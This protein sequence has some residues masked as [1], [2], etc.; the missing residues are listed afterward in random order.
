M[1]GVQGIEQRARLDSTY[2]A[3]NDP[4]GSPTE[5][6]LQQVIERDVRLERI[7]LAFDSEDVRLLDMQLG[8]I[9]DH[10]DSLFDRNR[11]RKDAEQGRFPCTRSATNEERLPGRNLSR[12]E[13]GQRS[14]QRTASDQVFD[15][16]MAARE[17]PNG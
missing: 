4:V 11:I 16:V 7:R 1:P 12:Q 6:G 2:F 17:L 13:I 9:F 10:N 5:S 15:G 14:R 3:Y 8:R